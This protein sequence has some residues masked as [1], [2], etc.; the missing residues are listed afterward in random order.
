V[1]MSR[2]TGY[3]SSSIRMVAERY[4]L[5]FFFWMTTISNGIN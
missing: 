4:M 2:F 5:D 1:S 3:E